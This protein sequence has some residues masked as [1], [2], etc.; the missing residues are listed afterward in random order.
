MDFFARLA[1][2]ALSEETAIKPLRLPKFAE[3][4]AGTSEV[5]APET[6]STTPS[7][8]IDDATNIKRNPIVEPHQ[9]EPTDMSNP[10]VKPL[11]DEPTDIM[12][13]VVIASM[14]EGSFLQTSDEIT[15]R[16]P[17]KK[18]GRTIE[19]DNKVNVKSHDGIKTN[20][21]GQT[22]NNLFSPQLKTDKSAENRVVTD[23]SY[24]D[25]LVLSDKEVERQ[26]ISIEDAPGNVSIKQGAG[27]C[28]P[29]NLL[30]LR[31][32][33]PLSA[34]VDY[35]INNFYVTQRVDDKPEAL[36]VTVDIGHIDVYTEPSPPPPAKPKCETHSPTLTLDD[37][38]KQRRRGER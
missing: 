33:E 3:S 14:H 7:V 32:P 8:G 5:Y 22:S 9:G 17:A 6:I 29:A 36:N 37:Y 25:A 24:G 12:K 2:R 10:V 27:S 23:R 4:A 19:F 21:P 38:L 16:E 11:K 13:P 18:Q 20:L 26:H 30:P 35:P 15:R 31:Q 34:S 28:E 1:H